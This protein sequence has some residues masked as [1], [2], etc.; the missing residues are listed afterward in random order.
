VIHASPPGTHHHVPTTAVLSATT[1]CLSA[2]FCAT[3]KQDITFGDFNG[4][5]IDSTFGRVRPAWLQA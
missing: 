5:G 3:V 4:S 1:D 2:Q